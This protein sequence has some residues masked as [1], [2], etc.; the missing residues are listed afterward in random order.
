MEKGPL[1]KSIIVIAV[2]LAVAFLSQQPYMQELGKK[3][4]TQLE[5]EVRGYWSSV[6]DWYNTNIYPEASKQAESGGE[7][8][9]EEVTK[10]KDNLSQN[11]WDKIENYFRE[12][13]SKVS[14]TEVK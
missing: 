6:V 7:V 13:F 4:Y 11:I 12:K 14:G 3:A 10:Q 8:I 1:I 5:R 9:K 2:V